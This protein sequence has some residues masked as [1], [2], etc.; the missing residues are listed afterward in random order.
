MITTGKG[1][2]G[3]GGKSAFTSSGPN[4]GQHAPILSS[5]HLSLHSFLVRIHTPPNTAWQRVFPDVR[6]CKYSQTKR[7]PVYS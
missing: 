4:C 6:K 2:E 7:S 3:R 5:P 1:G